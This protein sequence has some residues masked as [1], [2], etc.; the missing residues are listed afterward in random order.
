MSV[1]VR[2]PALFADRIDGIDRV[3]VEAATVESA[4][5]ALTD[6][7]AELAALVWT[8]DGTLNP[9]VILFLNDRQLDRSGI[10]ETVRSGDQLEII[11]AI[12]GGG[13][14][15]RSKESGVRSQACPQEL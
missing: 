13:G 5:R 2:L 8:A 11:P 4:L 15:W 9:L 3:E 10:D 14:R 1:R 12:E 7:H 6:R